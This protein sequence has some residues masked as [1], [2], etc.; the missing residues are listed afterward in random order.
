MPEFLIKEFLNL[1]LLDIIVHI[2]S[3]IELLK[4]FLSTIGIFFSKSQIKAVP[5]FVILK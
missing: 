1:Q 4:P 3:L 2:L 5:I